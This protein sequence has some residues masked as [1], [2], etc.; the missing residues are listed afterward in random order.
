MRGRILFTVEIRRR[1]Q[2]VQGLTSPV[3]AAR[4]KT[5]ITVCTITVAAGVCFTDDQ[6]D[7]NQRFL[8]TDTVE[9][10][11]DRYTAT[12]SSTAWTELFDR[13]PTF[14]FVSRWLYQELAQQIPQLSYITLI[15]ET[16]EIT[17]SYSP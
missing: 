7:E 10:I 11:I 1:C 15:N 14:E 4:G 12:L 8:D 5:P 2:V 9:E 17:A 13:R 16:L 3:R 6:L